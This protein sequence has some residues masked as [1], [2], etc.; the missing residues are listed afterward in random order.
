MAL[1]F[2]F[3]LDPFQ[4]EVIVITKLMLAHSIYG[5]IL[6]YSNTLSYLNFCHHALIFYYF[7]NIY[8]VLQ[9]IWKVLNL[10]LMS[11]L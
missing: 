10:I 8:M 11:I 2:P 1:N 6:N 3:E 5:N 4:K 7:D 9:E